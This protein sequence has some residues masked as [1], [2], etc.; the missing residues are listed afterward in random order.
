MLNH[1][2]AIYVPSTF[3]VGG[4]ATPVLIEKW[5]FAA[6]Q[7]MA[8]LFGGFTAYHAQGGWVSHDG[9]GLVSEN[10][11]VVKAYTN[12]VGL[13]QHLETVKQFAAEMAADMLQEAVSV[14]VDNTLDFV[15]PKMK[16]VA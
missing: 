12:D 11:L 1:M 9:T 7:M 3:A 4:K 2:V 6:K 13:S 5:S 14:E 10:I 16:L 8:K 15:S